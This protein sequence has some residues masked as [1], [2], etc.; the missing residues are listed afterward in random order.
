MFDSLTGLK[1][2][3]SP[4]NLVPKFETQESDISAFSS[5]DDQSIYDD[6]PTTFEEFVNLLDQLQ[7][8]LDSPTASPIQDNDF[9]L[10]NQQNDCAFSSSPNSS[11]DGSFIFPAKI[12][13]SSSSASSRKSR[14]TEPCGVCGDGAYHIHYGVLTCEGCKGF[15]KRTVQ[16]G[17]TDF[18]CKK[19]GCCDISFLTR[20]LCRPCRWKKCLDIGMSPN[21]VRS[22]HL[23]GRRGKLP[24]RRSYL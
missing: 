5:Y 2:S 1:S 20:S 16:R 3:S 22:G 11:E 19:K 13:R 17:N 23:A 10:E 12:R 8:Q 9:N 14:D 24:R 4:M 6:L 7:S 18:T 21:V 15:F